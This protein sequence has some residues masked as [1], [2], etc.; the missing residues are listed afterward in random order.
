MRRTFQ[1]RSL[2]N[3]S[4]SEQWMRHTPR[5]KKYPVVVAIALVVCIF[6]LGWALLDSRQVRAAPDFTLKGYDGSIYRMRD[7]RGKV[8]VLNFWASWCE[9]CR[10]EAAGFEQTWLDLR[11]RNIV[12][13]GINQADTLE[14][15]K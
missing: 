15:A 8:I 1:S 4:L 14:R 5:D 10:A 11:D 2:D 6:A 12:F 3:N 13:L 9:P 7:L